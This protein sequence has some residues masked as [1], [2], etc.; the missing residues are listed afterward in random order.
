MVKST[1]HLP[2]IMACTTQQARQ[3]LVELA[4]AANNA[5]AEIAIG[6]RLDRP[7]YRLRGASAVNPT[8][9]RDSIE[10]SADEF[11]K[12]WPLIRAVVRATGVRF[13]L[14]LAG[15]AAAV[16]DRHPSYDTTAAE[17]YLA[18]A[19]ERNARRTFN[20]VVKRFLD[21]RALL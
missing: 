9:L 13:S 5:K 14:M 20:P 12:E 19:H 15:T 4:I 1:S 6:T 16:L 17:R 11:R 2:L 3:R 8:H 21:D 18:L 10:I 7:I